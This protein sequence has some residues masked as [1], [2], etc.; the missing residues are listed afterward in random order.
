MIVKND[1]YFQKYVS[2]NGKKDA[3][4]ELKFQTSGST[5]LISLNMKLLV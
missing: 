2:F 3:K 5:K 4:Y 1:F